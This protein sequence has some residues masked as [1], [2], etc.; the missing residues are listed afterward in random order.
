MKGLTLSI[1]TIVS[2][3]Y[4]LHFG[5]IWTAYGHGGQLLGIPFA[6]IMIG[7]TIRYVVSKNGR[8]KKKAFYG[9]LFYFLSL[10]FFSITVEIIRSSNPNYFE[11]LYAEPEGIVNKIFIAF[12]AAGIIA[13]VLKFRQINNQEA[14]Q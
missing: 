14:V 7:L 1:F 11:L 10:A 5:Y 6:L 13:T 4:C 9:A 2:V 8:R 12:A 3:L